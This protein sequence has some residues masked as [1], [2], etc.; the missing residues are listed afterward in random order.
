MTWKLIELIGQ[1]KSGSFVGG[2]GKMACVVRV[3]WVLFVFVEKNEKI[4]SPTVH[5]ET[6]WWWKEVD[7][8]EEEL[9]NSYIKLV[10]AP[11]MG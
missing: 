10:L 4:H 7:V 9:M 2:Q 11:E 5:V 6:K 1:S 8:G 3:T